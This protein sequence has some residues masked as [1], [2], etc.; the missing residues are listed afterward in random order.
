MAAYRI[1]TLSVL[2]LDDHK[3]MQQVMRA[4]LVGLGV[5]DIVTVT[6]AAEAARLLRWKEFDIVFTDYRLYEQGGVT[7]A[8]F[9]KLVRA[10][11]KGDRF[12]PII[13][14]TADTT[15]QV[16]K[17]FRDAGVDEIL[18]KPVS[19]KAVWTKLAAV[20]NARRPFVEAPDFFGPT[21]RRVAHPRT[22][23]ERRGRVPAE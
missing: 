5:K 13:A 20:V 14:C 8:D 1:S 4:I 2:V 22:G 15:P 10:S 17:E 18:G 23:A 11:R 16:V 19:A 21:R 6:E 12:V 9:V 7:G 3:F